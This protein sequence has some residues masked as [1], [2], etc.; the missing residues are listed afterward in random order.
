MVPCDFD[1]VYRLLTAGKATSRD[2]DRQTIRDP[3]HSSSQAQIDGKHAD[4]ETSSQQDD[5]EQQLQ[6]QLPE[7][8]P[9]QEQVETSEDP[10]DQ[11]PAQNGGALLSQ[12]P[13][14]T[15]LGISDAE[16]PQ[17][18]G[19]TDCPGPSP[20]S[21]SQPGV[22]MLL[23]VLSLMSRLVSQ[24]AMFFVIMRFGQCLSRM[25]MVCLAKG[26][27]QAVS[28]TPAA[29][30]SSYIPIKQSIKLHCCPDVFA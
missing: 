9:E 5:H 20:G 22:L 12:G 29:C 11:R 23:C 10:S 7:Q 16:T 17:A 15:Q 21:E 19:Q 30:R 13:E 27:R 1:C 18:S 3:M 24:H 8:L 26:I 2:T 14:H 6:Q 25:L 28:A 4:Q